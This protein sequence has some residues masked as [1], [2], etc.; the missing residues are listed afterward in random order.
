MGK[1]GSIPLVSPLAQQ[2]GDS[3][4]PVPTSG[5]S[6]TLEGQTILQGVVSVPTRS[7][8]IAWGRM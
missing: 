6:K 1:H 4:H 8:A 7:N 3:W 5:D 2:H